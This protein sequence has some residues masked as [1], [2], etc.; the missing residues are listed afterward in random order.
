MSVGYKNGYNTDGGSY[1]YVSGNLPLGR[2]TH[3][4]MHEHGFWCPDPGHRR[5]I[6]FIETP[7]Q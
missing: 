3:S 1:Y 7:L 2:S 6:T 5:A 4:A